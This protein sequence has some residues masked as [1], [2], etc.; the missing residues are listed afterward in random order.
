[1]RLQLFLAALTI[2]TSSGPATAHDPFYGPAYPGV[3]QTQLCPQGFDCE[4]FDGRIEVAGPPAL[5]DYTRPPF[6]KLKETAGVVLEEYSELGPLTLTTYATTSRP[7]AGGS[8]VHV[9]SKEAGG[10]LKLAEWHMVRL[11]EQ[12]YER[13][14]YHYENGAWVFEKLIINPIAIE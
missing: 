9:L 2:V 10:H 3:P 7:I 1:M 11:N 8:A 5:P 12:V 13:R 14:L 4:D 6:R